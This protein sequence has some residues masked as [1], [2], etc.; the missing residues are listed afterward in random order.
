[1]M[2]DPEALLQALRIS[3]LILDS[4]LLV[5]VL[6]VSPEATVV[7]E[8][9]KRHFHSHPAWKKLQ[10]HI[11]LFAAAVLSCLVVVAKTTW[12]HCSGSIIGILFLLLTWTFPPL[13]DALRNHRHHRIP[14]A[15]SL[16][17][18]IIVLDRCYI[19]SQL[20]QW[21]WTVAGPCFATFYWWKVLVGIY[22]V[23]LGAPKF[24]VNVTLQLPSKTL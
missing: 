4:M 12:E 3:G 24:S 6:I 17:A 16:M 18:A 20:L 10:L 22:E 23:E 1:M 21:L 9:C 8:K 14:I 13:L 11:N 15:L 5:L 19:T 7:Y 2:H